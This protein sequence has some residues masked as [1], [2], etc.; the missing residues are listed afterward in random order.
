MSTTMLNNIG[1]KGSPCR[2]PFLV[3]KYDR[4]SSLTLTATLPPKQKIQP[5]KST[6]ARNLSFV[7]SALGMAIVLCHMLSLNQF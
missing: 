7:E 3:W 5:K 1:D 2:R 6:W 4:T